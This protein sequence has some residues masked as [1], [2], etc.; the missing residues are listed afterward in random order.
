MNTISSLLGNMKVRLEKILPFDSKKTYPLCVGG[1][2]VAPPEDCRG[3]K[4]FME[5]MSNHTPWQ[6]QYKLLEIIEESEEEEEEEIDTEL[7]QETIEEFRYWITRHEFDRKK[8]NKQ[9]QRYFNSQ[10]DQ[11]TVEEVYYDED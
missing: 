6:M 11:L 10:D 1:C 7:L 5:L 9:L 2:Y 4:A 8:I 3:F